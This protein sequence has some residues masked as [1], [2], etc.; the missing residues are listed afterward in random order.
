M[1]SSTACQQCGNWYHEFCYG[2]LEKPKPLGIVATFE[3]KFTP[4]S[5]RDLAMDTVAGLCR[6]RPVVTIEGIWGDTWTEPIC[7]AGI[8]TESR[9][10]IDGEDEIPI[11]CPMCAHVYHEACYGTP[12]ASDKCVTCRDNGPLHWMESDGLLN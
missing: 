9:L 5:L 6:P 2:E 12:L 3:F 7:R 11:R 8:C 10:T 1:S 4:A